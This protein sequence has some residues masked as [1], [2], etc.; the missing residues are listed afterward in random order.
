MFEKYQDPRETLLYKLD[1]G[2]DKEPTFGPLSLHLENRT[3]SVGEKEIKLTPT[4]YQI[5]WILVRAQGGVVSEAEIES[6][7]HEHKPEDRDLPLTNAIASNVTRVRR[8]LEEFEGENM[9]IGNVKEL[10]Y[11]LELK[12]EGDFEA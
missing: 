9:T 4:E 1:A 6:F 8:K 11:F 10:G 12:K 7:L 5:L 2:T 3:A